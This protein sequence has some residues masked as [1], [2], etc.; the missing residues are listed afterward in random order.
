MTRCGVEDHQG[1]R[2]AD[3]GQDLAQ[4]VDGVLRRLVGQ[5][6]GQ[7]L[8]VGAGG[9]AAATAG[10]LVEQLAGV[11]EVAVV[12]DG[13]RP[14]R[15]E[16]ERGLGV[17][18]DRGAGR[19]VAA[20]RDGEVAA[21]ATGSA[22]RRA[23][24]PPSRGPCRSSAGR[25]PRRRRPA[26]SWPRCW[27]ANSAVA[28]TAAASWPR[29]GQ[30]DPDDA[31]HQP[32]TSAPAGRRRRGP[33]LSPAP[34]QAVLPGV[35]QVRDRHVEGVG[36]PAAALLGGAGR[37]LAG[38]LDDQPRAAGGAQRPRR[39]GRAG[40][41][42]GSNAGTCRAS[43]SHTIRDGLSPN[44]ATAGES[45]TRQPEPRAAPAPDAHLR[46]AR[47][48]ARRRTRPGTTRRGR[49]RWPRG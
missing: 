48:R 46:D 4:R 7:Q 39:A 23:P 28:A 36:D 30:D 5:E 43:T 45:P 1:V 16:P 19:G 17:L 21:R 22:A 2:A 26:D 6:R 35:P 8:R 15:P 42:A 34:A 25:R 20:V 33:R 27:S 18:P 38:Q 37:A 10:E 12:A 40:G 44:S 41:R 3:P 13:E 31:A 49:G 14:A 47:P 32:A 24:G 11:D 9:E 29:F